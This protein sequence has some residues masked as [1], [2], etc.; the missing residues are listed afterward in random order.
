VNLSVTHFASY[1]TTTAVAWRGI[2]HDA[3]KFIKAIK[4][5]GVNGWATVPVRGESRRLEQN[6]CSAAKQWFAELAADFL[7]RE[8]MNPEAKW[9]LVPFPS[10]SAVLENEPDSYVSLELSKLLATELKGAGFEKVEVVDL[11]RWTERRPSAHSEGG[12]RDPQEIFP[13]L[14]LTEGRNPDFQYC[15]LV[16]DVLTS[17]ARLRSAAA[18]LTQSHLS[19][20]RGVVAGR[21]VQFPP[22]SP[23][24][25]LTEV[26][27]EFFPANRA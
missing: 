5:K 20:W 10:S 8:R 25:I 13:Y 22:T 18:L 27:P 4:G 11:I 23:F 2:D 1:L 26:L 3:S 24:D 19:V 6:N 14:S 7:M 17:G 9:G 15:V 12:A 16:D 21:T